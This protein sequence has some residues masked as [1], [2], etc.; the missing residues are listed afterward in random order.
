MKHT[1][2]YYYCMHCFC[3]RFTSTKRQAA[4]EAACRTFCNRSMEKHIG[5]RQPVA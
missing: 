1:L 5:K 3:N 4:N 2:S